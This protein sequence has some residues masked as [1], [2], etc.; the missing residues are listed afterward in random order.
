[1]KNG[2]TLI[3][4]LIGVAILAIVMLGIYGIFQG[5]L[6]MVNS[7][8]AR[9]TAQMLVNQ[10]LEEA[11]NLPYNKV[12]TISGIPSGTITEEVEITRNGIDFT[13]KTTV[14]YLDDPFDG[15]SADETDD[16]PNDYKRVKVKADWSGISKGTLF[17]FTDISPKG[18]EQAAGS[19]TLSIVCFDA[20]GASVAQANV[21]L[22]NDDIVPAIEANYL[23]DNDGQLTLAGA[24]ESVEFYQITLSKNGYSVDRTYGEDEVEDPVKLHSS[25]AEGKL[26]EISFAIDKLSIFNVNIVS[27]ETGLP[28]GDVPFHLQGLKEIGKK[29]PTYKYSEDHSVDAAGQLTILNLEWDSYEFSVDKEVTGF[30]LI[31]PNPD[32]QP[33]DLLPDTITPVTLIFGAENTLIIT[34]KDSENSEPIFGAGV[35]IFNLDLGYDEIVPTDEQGQA[36]FTPLEED[37]YDLEIQADTYQDYSSAVTILGDTADEALMEKLP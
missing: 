27:E 36:F 14:V 31:S 6:R 21:Y 15:T 16:L 4:T 8:R 13:V 11:R 5:S 28:I 19:G 23:T 34:V 35:R 17:G 2:F 7:S 3:E 9:L 1:M 12:G 26:T 18:A 22:K 32:E 25:V 10:K 24:P 29:V 20:S 33:I 37:D 30:D